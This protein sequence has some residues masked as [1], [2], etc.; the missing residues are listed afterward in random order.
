M[1]SSRMAKSKPAVSPSPLSDATPSVTSALALLVITI[2]S[3]IPAMLGGY[4]WDDDVYVQ[5]N[6]ALR[7][8]RGLWNIWTRTSTTPQYYP[9]VHTTFWIEY[10]LRGA[11]LSAA[12]GYKIVNILLHA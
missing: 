11:G 6:L 5:H 3:Y 8:F 12:L 9:L 7:S 1:V 4:I 10:H 2:L